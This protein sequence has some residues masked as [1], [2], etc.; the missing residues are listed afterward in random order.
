[1]CKFAKILTINT[2][3]GYWILGGIAYH[4]PAH[5]NQPVSWL[6]KFLTP[7]GQ[8]G[9][10]MWTINSMKFFT[11]YT[12]LHKCKENSNSNIFRKVGTH[13]ERFQHEIVCSNYQVIIRM[14]WRKLF[15]AFVH[16][17]CL[18]MCRYKIILCERAWSWEVSCCQFGKCETYFC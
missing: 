5:A 1:M 14:V 6:L 3:E 8:L 9:I 2:A 11:Y 4:H 10:T 18:K 15:W 17:K 12:F 7:P 16:L 13:N